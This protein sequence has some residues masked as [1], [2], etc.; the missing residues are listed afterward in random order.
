MDDDFERKL[1]KEEYF[2]LQ[3]TI[4]DYNRQ[5]WVIKSLGITGTGAVI[6]LAVQQ[7]QSLIP[8]LGCA[9]PFFFWILES[10][11]KHFQRGFY[12][13]AAEIEEILITDCNLKGPAIY[14][15]W[16][17]AYKRNTISKRTGY[18]WDGLFNPSV[19]ISYMLEI[20]FLIIVWIVAP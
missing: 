6:A 17:R 11:W 10:Q 16:C 8:L 15:G 3:T 2:F 14:G 4:E 19:F 12:P 20:L 9:I 7:S 5:I 1:L 13:R 18:L